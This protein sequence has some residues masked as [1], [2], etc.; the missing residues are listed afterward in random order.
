MPI[1]MTSSRRDQDVLA[2]ATGREKER[3]GRQSQKGQGNY[4]NSEV[5][6]AEIRKQG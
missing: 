6:A 4:Q 1:P 3:K 5:S 2:N